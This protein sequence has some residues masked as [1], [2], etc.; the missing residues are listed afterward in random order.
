MRISKQFIV[1]APVDKV[2]D[3]VR[4]QYT[5]IGSWASAVHASARKEGPADSVEVGTSRVCTTT[6]GAFEET[7]VELDET[8]RR[9]TY[10][11]NDMPA[12]IKKA[13]NTWTLQP[14]ASGGTLIELAGQVT[15]NPLYAFM[16]LM[17]RVQLS[18]ILN[19]TI[20]ELAHYVVHGTLHPRKQRRKGAYA[21]KQARKAA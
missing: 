12:Y 5:D 8:G 20:E 16:A 1:P 17:M 4:N 11:V 3:V 2:W 14:H 6:L 19:N 18:K 7:V 15:F 21:A 13:Q 10:R 9:L